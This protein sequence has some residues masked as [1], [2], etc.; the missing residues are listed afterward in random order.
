MTMNNP[1]GISLPRF[2]VIVM[3]T[4][5][6]VGGRGNFQAGKDPVDPVSPQPS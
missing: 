4:L 5:K 2:F 1:E 6:T 3:V